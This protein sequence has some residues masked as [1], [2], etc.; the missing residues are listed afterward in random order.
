V[1]DP[2]RCRVGLCLRAFNDAEV[3]FGCAEAAQSAA[4]VLEGLGHDVEEAAPV[5]LY[6]PD[7]LSGVR[8]LLA[9]NAA[10][11]LDSWSA[12][13]GR[14]LGSATW[15]PRRGD[16]GR[17]PPSA[18][19]SAGDAGPAAGAGPSRLVVVVELRPVGHAGDGR[20]AAAA[21]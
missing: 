7:L 3:D 9:V 5:D 18:A 20:A 1:A 6:E 15:S 2:G 19:P 21:R 12:A 16:R 10:A 13:L 11:E 17:R 14:P 8:R 4:V